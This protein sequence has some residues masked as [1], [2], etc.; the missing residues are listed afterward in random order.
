MK[1]TKKQ[2]IDIETLPYQNIFN[3]T[4]KRLDLKQEGEELVEKRKEIHARLWNITNEMNEIDEQMR[5][6][7]QRIESRLGDKKC[8]S[9]I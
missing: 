9:N 6:D 3:L 8:S 4:K 2:I 7:V 1:M 5:K